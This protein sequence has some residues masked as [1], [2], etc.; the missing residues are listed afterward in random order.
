MKLLFLSYGVGP[1]QQEVEFAVQCLKLHALHLRV[2][3][4]IIFTDTPKYF[5][6][7]AAT[8]E[9][10]PTSQW[11][12]WGGLKNYNH[13]RKILSL[14]HA[15]QHTDSPILLLDGDI[16]FR[17]PLIYI[18]PKIGPGRGVM[19]IR[20]GQISK[21]RSP[22][23]EQLR[24]LLLSEKG[25]KTG[26]P[27]DAWMW[28]AGV[29]GLHPQ[30][31]PLL[32]EVLRLT[33]LLCEISTLHILEQLAFSWVLSQR[34]ELKGVSDIVFHYWPPY[35]RKPFRE[36]LPD[37][38]ARVRT[39]PDSERAAFLYSFRPRPNIVRRCK[40]VCK[41]ALE[42]SGILHGYARSNEW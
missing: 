26:I 40:F 8:I 11:Q 10:I 39:L 7:I 18:L 17:K 33:D 25:Q 13:R 1:H 9:F 34:I 30:Q 24:Q 19:H 15:L 38:M 37:I 36:I 32:T 2:E 27:I 35:L 21:V 41:R 12:E 20:E 31:R 14:D 5:D 42:T 3:D 22:M 28:N 6:N 23:Y 29:I 16:W 4:L